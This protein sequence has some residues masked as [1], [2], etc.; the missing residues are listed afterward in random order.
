ME[1]SSFFPKDQN[2]CSGHYHLNKEN[3]KIN[4]GFF[5]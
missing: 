1:N 4:P 2:F 5:N 3:N